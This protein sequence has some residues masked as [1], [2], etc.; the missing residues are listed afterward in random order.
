MPRRATRAPVKGERLPEAPQMSERALSRSIVALATRLGWRV[1][2]LSDSRSLRSHHP[3]F[4]DLFMVRRGRILAVELKAERGR[5]RE[6]QQ[7]WLDDLRAAGVWTHVW[8]P[9]DWRSGHVETWLR[10]G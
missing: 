6:G 9:E 3:G 1:H 4:P 2:T 7:E 8:R 10:D 5:M